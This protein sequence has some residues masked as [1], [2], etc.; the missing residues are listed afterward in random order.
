VSQLQNY[1]VTAIASANLTGVQRWRVSANVYNDAGVDLGV[2]SFNWPDA[3]I[4]MTGAQRKQIADLLAPQI[5][6]VMAGLDT[7]I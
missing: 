5:L 1:T 7:T 2:F 6:R 3:W 4:N